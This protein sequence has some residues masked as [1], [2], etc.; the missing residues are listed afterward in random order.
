MLENGNE[1]EGCAWYG[2]SSLHNCVLGGHAPH[3]KGAGRPRWLPDEG[4]VLFPRPDPL[5]ALEESRAVN[6]LVRIHLLGCL[7]STPAI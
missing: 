6:G 5:S 1:L 4:K 7:Y 2:R 3:P